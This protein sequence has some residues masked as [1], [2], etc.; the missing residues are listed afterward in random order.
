MATEA[1]F[2][3][4]YQEFITRGG[5]THTFDNTNVENDSQTEII[6]KRKF[7]KFTV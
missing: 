6:S 3:R 5:G 7:A 1:E 2:E 4:L